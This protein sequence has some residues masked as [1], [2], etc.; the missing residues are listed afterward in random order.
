MAPA[1]CRFTIASSGAWAVALRAQTLLS[2]GAMAQL[3][4]RDLLVVASP[5]VL[6]G[7]GQPEAAARPPGRRDACPTR[8]NEV[9]SRSPARRAGRLPK[10]EADGYDRRGLDAGGTSAPPFRRWEEDAVAST[11]GRPP[12]SSASHDAVRAAGRRPALLGG[13]PKLAGF[14]LHDPSVIPRTGN[15]TLG[16]E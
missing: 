8:G 14:R 7:G 9:G 12:A 11:A 13:P 16:Q 15:L 1:T 3:S 2:N 10:V 4:I 5:A 6:G